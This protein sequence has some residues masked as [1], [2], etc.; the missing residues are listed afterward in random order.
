M[1]MPNR[2]VDRLLLKVNR[3]LKGQVLGA[4]CVVQIPG[5][6]AEYR[7]SWGPCRAAVLSLRTRH[8]SKGTLHPALC[9]PK[10]ALC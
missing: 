1:W 7:V 10:V 3:K 9:T 8:P 4:K 5:R 6:S 2:S